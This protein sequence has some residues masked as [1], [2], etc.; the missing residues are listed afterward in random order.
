ME[1]LVIS[2]IFD[3]VERSYDKMGERYHHFRDNEK[4]KSEL[5]KFSDLLPPSGEILDA[6]LRN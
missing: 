1:V 5:K 4:F 3:T 2:D 6:G